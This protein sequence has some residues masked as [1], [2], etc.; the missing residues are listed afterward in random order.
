MRLMTPVSILERVSIAQPKITQ[1][2]PHVTMRHG[3]PHCCARANTNE[4]IPSYVGYGLQRPLLS[5]GRNNQSLWNILMLDSGTS[6]AKRN[7]ARC[8][9]TSKMRECS[10]DG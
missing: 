6:Q 9:E 10:E 7:A 2:D 8:D 1:E 4:P 5:A 3:S